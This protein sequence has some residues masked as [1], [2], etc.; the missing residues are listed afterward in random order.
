M[1]RVT[2]PGLTFL[3]GT[4]ASSVALGAQQAQVFSTTG[5][6]CCVA[7]VRH[8]EENG[9]EAEIE[10]LDMGALMQRKVEAGIDPLKNDG[11][12]RVFATYP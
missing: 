9:Y 4:I 11:S 3:I 5:C 2:I 6:G 10:N 12:T 1:K 7:W 8:L